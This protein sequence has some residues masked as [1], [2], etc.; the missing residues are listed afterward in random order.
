MGINHTGKNLAVSN[1][2]QIFKKFTGNLKST[3]G[4][5][6]GTAKS[7]LANFLDKLSS[8]EIIDLATFADIQS[9]DLPNFNEQE[10][11]DKIKKRKEEIAEA[12]MKAE[13]INS[14]PQFQNNFN[15]S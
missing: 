13:Y 10:F 11:E 7:G 8:N 4:T 5:N 12:K 9:A 2:T 14:L 15:S 6:L 1:A 3:L